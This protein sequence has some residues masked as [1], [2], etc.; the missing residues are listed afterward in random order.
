[1]TSR[2]R[3]RKEPLYLFMILDSAA[4]RA[5]VSYPGSTLEGEIISPSI[6]VGEIARHYD[7]A[8]GA[9]GDDPGAHHLRLR[10]I[11]LALRGAPLQPR[12][13]GEWLSAVA[14]EWRCGRIT[15][16][17]AQQL[18]G[19]ELLERGKAESRG[20]AR[21]DIGRGVFEVDRVWHQSVLTAPEASPFVIR[22]LA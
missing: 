1:M 15:E 2:D 10:A 17:R 20:S 21:A 5:T 22:A 16:E 6:Y 13:E 11:A 12:G 7:P 19:D 8:A 18:L 9:A 14:H 3:N 4:R